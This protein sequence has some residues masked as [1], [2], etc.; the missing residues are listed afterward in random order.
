MTKYLGFSAY[1]PLDSLNFFS[2]VI[3]DLINDRKTN[4]N[5]NIN[6]LYTNEFFLLVSYYKLGIVHCTFLGMSGYNFRKIL[7]FLSENIIYLNKQ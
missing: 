6:P 2:M 1:Y 5:V 4:E 7:Y 3:K